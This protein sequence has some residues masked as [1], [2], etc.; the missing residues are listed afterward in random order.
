MYHIFVCLSPDIYQLYFDGLVQERCNSSA[1]AMALCLS[2]TNPS[3]CPHQLSP[4][5]KIVGGGHRNGFV[6]SC[7]CPSHIWDFLVFADRLLLG[8]S[9][10]LVG[11]FIMGLP[12]PDWLLVMQYAQF[13]PGLWLVEHFLR[14]YRKLAH[15]I[16]LK[17][18]GWTHYGISLA[19]WASPGLINFW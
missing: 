19:W 12:K 17:F 9:S 15:Q 11:E 3:I 10:N 4:A 6:H 8:L 7:V 13:L 1:L 16:E 2:C 5:T 18:G 14:I